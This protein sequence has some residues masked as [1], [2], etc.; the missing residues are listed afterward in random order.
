M[1]RML[2]L[3][4]A[5]AL[6]GTSGCVAVALVGA[7]G[8]GAGFGYTQAKARKNDAPTRRAGMVQSARDTERA[9]DAKLLPAPGDFVECTL[10]NGEHLAMSAADCKAKGGSTS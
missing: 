9:D 8:A 2:L 7:A 5:V 10:K 3:V 4:L 1:R 6:L